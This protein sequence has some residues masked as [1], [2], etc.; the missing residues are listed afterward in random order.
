LNNNDQS[1]YIDY[2]SR[3]T[4]LDS[5][6]CHVIR[7]DV[8]NT[9]CSKTTNYNANINSSRNPNIVK[10]EKYTGA[11][12]ASDHLRT[13]DNRCTKSDVFFVTKNTQ[14][15]PFACGAPNTFVPLIPLRSDILVPGT[16]GGT[17]TIA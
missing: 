5:S 4:I 8:P 3:K 11:L 2:I 16:I 12:D 13:A 10:P 6:G 7:D 14:G 1:S 9:C 17:N 15:V